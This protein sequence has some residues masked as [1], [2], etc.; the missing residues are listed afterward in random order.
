MK[1]FY[2]VQFNLLKFIGNEF[3]K[4]VH[5]Y[6]RVVCVKMIEISIYLYF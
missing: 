6:V 2:N 1:T 4:C 3:P 5:Q